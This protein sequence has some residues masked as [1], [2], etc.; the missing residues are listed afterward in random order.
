MT[1]NTTLCLRC[2]TFHTGKQGSCS[3]E[4]AALIQVFEKS[5][6]ELKL[7]SN[8]KLLRCKNTVHIATFNIMT[9]NRIGQLLEL[10]TSAAEHNIDIG[11]IQE[12][13]YYPSKLKIKYHN[14]SNGCHSIWMGN[15]INAI[16]GG[17]GI[18]LSPHALKSL[19]IYIY[20]YIYIY[21]YYSLYICVKMWT[22]HNIYM[23]TNRN[24][25][26]I[27]IYIYKL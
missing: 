12:H 23:Y 11:C 17:I 19:N 2:I 20:I 15:S 6:L 9:L 1:L 3:A 8:L 26:Y 25:I 5:A 10:T 4:V 24:I 22:I 18:L 14:T 13:R 21:T 27:Y 16:I 7:K